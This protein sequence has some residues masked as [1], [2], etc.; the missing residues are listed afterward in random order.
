M[1]ILVSFLQYAVKVL[2]FAATAGVGIFLGKKLRERKDAK[3][4]Q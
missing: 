1:A 2:L 3:T 4:M